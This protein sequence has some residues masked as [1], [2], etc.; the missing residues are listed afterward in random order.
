MIR[1]WQALTSQEEAVLGTVCEKNEEVRS[2][3]QAG[4]GPAPA[5]PGSHPIS[6]DS[7]HA[8][9]LEPTTATR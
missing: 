2:R 5:S 3:G 9:H 8:H 7:K 1:D 4:G 6:E